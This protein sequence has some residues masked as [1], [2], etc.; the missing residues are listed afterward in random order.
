MNSKVSGQDLKKWENAW[1]TVYTSTALGIRV[2]NRPKR[3]K[4][5]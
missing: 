2:S 3:A 5:T 1:M 4:G